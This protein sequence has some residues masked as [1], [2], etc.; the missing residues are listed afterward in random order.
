[1]SSTDLQ[2]E[3]V[4]IWVQGLAEGEDHV[5]CNLSI[6]RDVT[7][8][9]QLLSHTLDEDIVADLAFRT[10]TRSFLTKTAAIYCSEQTIKIL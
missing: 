2:V 1:M 7:R 6:L 10:S 3:S 8:I 5:I 9:R 4:S